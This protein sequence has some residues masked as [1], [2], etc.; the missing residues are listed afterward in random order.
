[1]V[2]PAQHR[3]AGRGQPGQD[4]REGGAQVGRHHLRARERRH[5]ADDRRRAVH[6]DPGTHPVELGDV[7]EA[8]LEDGLGHHRGTLGDRE[9]R[10]ELRLHVGGKARIGLGHDVD[11]AKR[12]AAADAHG[13]VL[14]AHLDAGLLEHPHHGAEMADA[15]AEQPHVAAG[16]ADSAG[17]GAAL[18]PV[19][20]HGV[21][22]AVQPVH[23][24][25]DDDARALV[26]DAGAHRHQAG[27]QVGDLGLARGVDD[28]G[29]S[30]RQGRRHQQVLGGADGGERQHDAGPGQAARGAGIDV[31]GLETDLGA[32][33][34]KPLEMDVDRPRADGAAARQR[35][36]GLA[37]ARQQ[38]AQHQDRGAHLRD[39]VVGRLG[40]SDV[41]ADR[42][43]M[44]GAVLDILDRDAVLFEQQPHGGDVVDPWHVA[45]HH[46]L[47][48]QQARHQQLQG[49]VLGAADRDLAVQRASATDQETVHCVSLSFT[50][51]AWRRRAGPC[52]C[53]TC[54][55]S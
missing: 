26:G 30:I 42:Q 48:R 54:R 40:V 52:I 35:N 24:I 5:A 2:D 29:A 45:E 25:D 31:A 4:Q 18:D 47:R 16:D 13:A 51:A 19:G 20:D 10:H 21:T 37:R 12:T 50:C 53:R 9:Q 41:A 15:A 44:A 23:A 17:I 7:H 55:R 27:D 3:L 38:R 6:V 1:M 22:R 34:F 39:D 33:R 32:E 43:G 36:A 11:A 46:A 49:G 8:V 28:L 14:L